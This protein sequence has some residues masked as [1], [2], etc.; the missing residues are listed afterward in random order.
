MKAGWFDT[1]AM[2]SITS[3]GERFTVTDLLMEGTGNSDLEGSRLATDAAPPELTLRGG[4]VKESA[5]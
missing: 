4:R 1:S 5:E 2:Y 3:A